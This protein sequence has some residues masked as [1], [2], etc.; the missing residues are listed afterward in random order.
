[1]F[2]KKKII[3]PILLFILV[4]AATPYAVNLEYVGTPIKNKISQALP[5]PV[6]F[7]NLSWRWLPVPS[8]FL[9]EI[10]LSREGLDITASRAA[11]RFFPAGLW[12]QGSILQLVLVRPD[13]R[14]R[15][16]DNL[17]EPAALV[18]SAGGDDLI[19]R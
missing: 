15:M 9:N 10:R 14:L 8:L 18:A 1:M 12:R 17:K 11:V 16:T 3:I 7:D 5:V 19:N 4:V 6:R 2:L 13:I